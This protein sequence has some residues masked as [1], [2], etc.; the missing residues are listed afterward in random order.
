MVEEDFG[1]NVGEWT[2]KTNSGN[3]EQCRAKTK[4]NNNNK[5]NG[6]D[7]EFILKLPKEQT[8]RGQHQC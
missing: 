4:P 3:K 7:E 2:G 5:G 8:K 6:W 1:S